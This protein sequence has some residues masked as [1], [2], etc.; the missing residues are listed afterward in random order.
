VVLLFGASDDKDIAGMLDA[1]LPRVSRLIATR[2]THPRAATP[3]KIAALAQERGCPAEVS[4]DPAPALIQA[5]AL[6]GPGDVLLAAGSLFV[7][8]AVLEEW[9]SI[10]EKY[11]AGKRTVNS[12]GDPD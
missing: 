8:G 11:L 1:L 5:L 2:S 3:E 6:V 7:A 10:R 9:P 12:A 4:G